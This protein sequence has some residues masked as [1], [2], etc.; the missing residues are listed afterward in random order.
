MFGMLD[1]RAH[2]LYLILFGIPLIILNLVSIF[3]LSFIAYQVGF[4]FVE[5]WAI[6]IL[7]SIGSLVLIEILWTL[8][9]FLVID[10]LFE[11]IF[12]LFVDVIPAD[13]RTKE[14]ANIVVYHGERGITA[15]LT[16]KHP[17][18]WSDEDIQKL[19]KLD[20][21][22]HLFFGH[23][24]VDRCEQIREYFTENPEIRYSERRLQE[25]IKNSSVAIKWQEKVFANKA[26]RKM[27]IV[28]SIFLLLILVNPLSI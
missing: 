14:E 10:K 20:W 22:E 4:S 25:Y 15:L 3:G 23:I 26:Y 11:F 6:K 18:E 16:K 21:V 19:S 9:V 24:V 1:Y 2:K 27:A 7:L 17:T 13:G 5:T 12:G 28:Y 8:V